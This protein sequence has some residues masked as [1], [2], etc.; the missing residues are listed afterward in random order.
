MAED[1]ADA[2][3]TSQRHH[4]PVPGLAHDQILTDTVHGG[5]R[6]MARAQAVPFQRLD[7]QAAALG[8]A[9]QDGPNRVTVQPAALNASMLAD[10]PEDEPAGNL[11]GRKPAA[12]YTNRAGIRICAERKT[13]LAPG[14]LLIGL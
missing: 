10:R 1:F 3:I 4:G 8:G 2:D 7:L 9:P 11:G 5:L 12:Q 6:Y 13:H 14:S